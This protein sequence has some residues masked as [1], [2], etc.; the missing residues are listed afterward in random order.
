VSL[1]KKLLIHRF[2]HRHFA[3][4]QPYWWFGGLPGQPLPG[5]ED[6]EMAR[7]ATRKQARRA[8]RCA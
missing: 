7:R 1:R 8:S 2:V 5:I 4:E 3:A 6:F